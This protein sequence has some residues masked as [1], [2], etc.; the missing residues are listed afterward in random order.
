MR[1]P[2]LPL[3]EREPE[4]PVTARF[5]MIESLSET[6]CVL[7]G[8]TSFPGS[9][10]RRPSSPPRVAAPS[11]S[12]NRACTGSQADN[13]QFLIKII[14]PRPKTQISW[15]AKLKRRVVDLQLREHY[16]ADYHTY[17]D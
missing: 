16:P 2:R 17:G 9:M 3:P 10:F 11:M 1:R 12:G 8:R 4:Q 15:K 14:Q 7:Q 6:G 5:A 13:N